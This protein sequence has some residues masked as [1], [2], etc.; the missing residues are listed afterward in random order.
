MASTS[1]WAMLRWTVSCSMLPMA[2]D[3]TYSV[4]VKIPAGTSMKCC[5]TSLILPSRWPS[6]VTTS[7]PGFRSAI[8]IPL[9]PADR[10]QDGL[11]GP[12][13]RR[14]PRPTDGDEVLEPGNRHEAPRLEVNQYGIAPEPIVVVAGRRLGEGNQA[15]AHVRQILQRHREPLLGHV[16]PRMHDLDLASGAGRRAVGGL[17]ELAD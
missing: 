17:R 14:R 16:R 13:L 2:E 1:P 12:A 6:F 10:S 5:P 7:H 15:L 8:R 9:L 11:C 4:P 3:G